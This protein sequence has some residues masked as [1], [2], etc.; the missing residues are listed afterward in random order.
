MHY[1]P[2]RMLERFVERL[3]PPPSR[4]D[5]SG[6]LTECSESDLQFLANSVS[7]VPGLIWSQLRR[8]IGWKFLVLSAAWDGYVLGFVLAFFNAAFLDQ[9]A[10]SWTRLAA[11]WFVWVAGAALSV[12]Y[13]PAGHPNPWN[14]RGWAKA[15]I[16]AFGVAIAFRVPL[17]GTLA[18][19]SAI[20]VVRVALWMVL[21]LPWVKLG[22][23]SQPLSLD[24]LPE[25]AHTFQRGIWWRN[26]R[27]SFVA[28]VLIVLKGWEIL[29]PQ[30]SNVPQARF[31]L[32]VCSS[33]FTSFTFVRI[34]VPFPRGIRRQSCTSTAGNWRVNATFF[35][36]CR[37]GI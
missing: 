20:V 13:S 4:E 36:P 14:V 5:V 32:P 17:I 19:L 26:A 31:S 8:R 33:S 27:E 7:V 22:A 18:A 3:I 23:L 21:T 12:V 37:S 16:A 24:T 11:V 25:H 1:R 29:G 35:A 15:F 28:V 2:P 6:D 30:A 34:P 10:W 9:G